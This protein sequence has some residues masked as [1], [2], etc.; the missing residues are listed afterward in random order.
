M[1]GEHNDSMPPTDRVGEVNAKGHHVGALDGIR[2]IAIIAVMVF[3]FVIEIAPGGALGVDLF[4]ALSAFLI[5][6][7]LLRERSRYGSVDLPAFYVRRAARLFP[8]L[9]LF[10][11][12][13]APPIAVLLG[14]AQYIPTNTLAVALY[15]ADFGTAGYFP[16]VEPYGHTWSLAVEEQFY[17]IW[18]A[19]LLFV[20]PRRAKLVRL[21]II[22]FI[23]GCVIAVAGTYVLGTGAN[24]FLPTGH[25]PALT[26]GV[27]AAFLGER[28]LDSVPWYASSSVAWTAMAGLALMFFSA[29][30]SWPDLL[31]SLAP[32]PVLLLIGPLI[33]HAASGTPSVLNKVLA[34]GVLRWFGTRSYGLY[35]Y[36]TAFYFAATTGILQLKRSYT[37]VVTVAVSLLVAE[38]SF[39]YLERPFTERGRAWSQARRQQTQLTT[40]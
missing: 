26:V 3:H 25:L 14:H 20:V 23:V 34:F 38:L 5:T 10:L 9:A 17:L 2:G 29:R 1:T 15:V 19:V 11:V 8:A 21:G 37:A 28:K 24:Y 40:K 39:R 36:H 18:P 30:A 22:M 16:L 35:L 6:G 12:V 27:L 33:L 32:L 31:Q 13:I 7:M 4:F